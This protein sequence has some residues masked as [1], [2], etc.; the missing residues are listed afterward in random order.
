MEPSTP[1]H[2]PTQINMDETIQ[3]DKNTRPKFVYLL[4]STSGA[5]Y[6]GATIDLDHR[7]RQHNKEIKGGA[8]ATSAKVAR[9]EVW[10]RHCYV[11]GFPT[12]KSALQFEWRWKQ[13][14]R[15]LP[16]SGNTPLENRMKALDILLAMD[17]PTSKA[18]SYS[19]WVSPPT[20]HIE[21]E[22]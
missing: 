11:S 22:N 14:H 13:I 5:T 6:V 9:G 8:H 15:K 4:V 20:I 3:E 16:R 2:S 12:W 19:E 18:I 17:R 10:R 21:R 7:L 1:S